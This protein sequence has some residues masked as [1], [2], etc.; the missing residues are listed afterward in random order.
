M[1]TMLSQL[2]FLQNRLKSR[3]AVRVLVVFLKARRD[4]RRCRWGGLAV[5]NDVSYSQ[6]AAT[7]HV[8]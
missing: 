5:P 7:L 4:G 2:G 8:R 1:L 3:K 6:Y